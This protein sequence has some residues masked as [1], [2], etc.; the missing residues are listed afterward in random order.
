MNATPVGIRG[1]PE[2]P[3]HLSMHS[4]N[5]AQSPL[6]CLSQCCPGGQQ[7][8]GA[9]IETCG[10]ETPALAAATGSRATER[11]VKATIMVRTMVMGGLRRIYIP[12][13]PGSS[14]VIVSRFDCRIGCSP[15]NAASDQSATRV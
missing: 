12:V 13:L 11:A 6:V 4:A 7:S 3:E 14:D 10:E 5:F 1:T 15:R 2:T 8:D 9:A